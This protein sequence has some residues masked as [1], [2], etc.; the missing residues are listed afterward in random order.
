MK[1]MKTIDEPHGSPWKNRKDKTTKRH[2]ESDEY[3]RQNR[4]TTWKT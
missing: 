1:T 3:H 4:L 2:Q